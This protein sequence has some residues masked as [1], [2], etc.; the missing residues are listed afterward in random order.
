MIKEC[1]KYF[2]QNRGYERIFLKMKEKWLSYEKIAGTIMIENPS[3]EEREAVKELFGKNFDDKIIKFKMSDFEKALR[4]SRYKDITILELLE[5]YFGEKLISKKQKNIFKE[6]NREEFFE[7]IKRRLMESED[8]TKEAEILLQEIKIEKQGI[9]KFESDNSQTE[10][11]I[12]FGIKAVNFLKNRKERIKIAMLGAVITSN[13]HYFD[14]GTSAGNMLIYMLSKINNIPYEKESEKILEIYYHSGIEVD[15]ISSFTVG[16]NIR[17]FTEKG[18][19]GAYEEFIKNSEEYIITMSNLRNITGAE[20]FNKKVF[21]V[22]NQMVFSYLCEQLKDSKV[23]FICT[24][25]QP[26]T[27]SLILLD[28]LCKSDCKIYYS[29]DIDPEG[30]EIADRLIKRGGGKIIPWH[31]SLEDYEKSISNEI[32]SETRIKKLE[33]I[34]NRYFEEIILKMKDEKRAGYQELILPQIIEDIKK[35]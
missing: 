16:F 30:L 18:V 13:P 10:D 8:Y 31:F 12:Y 11:M 7:N 28:M 4:E 34:K 26:K 33:K 23:S 21:V 27:A 24:G 19:H 5:E 15:S 20:S 6:Q 32:I 9:Y 17:L 1:V 14:K 3:F 2:R 29:G 35:L 25:G 22:E